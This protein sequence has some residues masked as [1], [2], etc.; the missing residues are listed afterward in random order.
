MS[1]AERQARMDANRDRLRPAVVDVCAML[2]EQAR[3]GLAYD[4]SADDLADRLEEICLERS[5][6]EEPGRVI[7]AG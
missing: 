1:W 6:W 3:G 5:Q 4:E 7:N 2:R